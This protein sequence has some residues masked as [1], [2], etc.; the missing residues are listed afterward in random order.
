LNALGESAVT[1]GLVGEERRLEL[2]R[3]LTNAVCGTGDSSDDE[4]KVAKKIVDDDLSPPPRARSVLQTAKIVP[5]HPPYIPTYTPPIIEAP[6]AIIQLSKPPVEEDSAP[7]LNTVDLEEP[8]SSDSNPVPLVNI[9]ELKNELKRLLNKRELFIA[10]KLSGSTQDIS[11]KESE[12][13]LT[14][15]DLE[16]NMF[17]GIIQRGELVLP[18]HAVKSQF[19]QQFVSITSPNSNIHLEKYVTYLNKLKDDYKGKVWTVLLCVESMLIIP[20]LHA[21]M[22]STITPILF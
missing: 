21:A 18:V 5:I 22:L 12:G 6:V 4:P 14:R 10:Y 13:V 1:T 8:V 20:T 17:N 7:S 19:L 16:L 15:V 2:L 11:L 9:S 3:R